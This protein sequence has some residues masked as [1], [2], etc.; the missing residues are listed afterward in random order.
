MMVHRGIITIL[1]AFLVLTVSA[2]AQDPDPGLPDTVRI[3]SVATVAGVD[4]G[5]PVTL[6]NDENLGGYTLPFIWDSADISIDSVSYIGTRIPPSAM[7]TLNLDNPN[8][9][10]LM[11]MVDF[12]GLNPLP[13]GDGLLFTI[14]FAVPS[15]TPD[16]FV[17]IDSSFYPPAGTFTLAPQ[18]G[19]SVTPQFIA[20]Q[21]K[22]GDPQPPPVIV[23]SN[24]S[25]VFNAEVGGG[26]PT[27][28]VQTITNGGGQTLN[29]QTA[30]SSAWLGVNPNQGTA[31]STVVITANI[32][33]L[34]AG[35]YY[36]TV[37]VTAAGATNS[38]Q[39]F[40]VTLNLTV[41]P[42]IIYLEP[43]S[44]YF[45]SLQDDV[46]PDSQQLLIDNIGQG[47]LNWTATEN[48]TWL[49]L[50]AY[51][52]VGT[53]VI[54]VMVDNAGLGPGVYTEQIVVSDPTATN[55]PQYAIV[56]FE[57]FSAYPVIWAEPESFYAVGSGT[58]D[59][60]DRTLLIH[61]N[62]G[63]IMDWT[64]SEPVDWM[65]VDIDTGSA[66]Q[67]DPGVV[68]VSFDGSQVYFGQHHSE[69]T[70]TSGN[71]ANS[72]VTIP[73][74][75]WKMEVPQ[76]LYVSTNNLYFTG[77]ECGLYG[78]ID[79]QYIMITAA[80]ATPPLN[81]TATYGA[82]WL[83]VAPLQG[84]NASTVTVE[85][86]PIGLAPGVYEDTIVIS[87]LTAINPSEKVAVTLTILPS[88]SNADLGMSVD[89]LVYVFCYTLVGSTDLTVTM[90]AVGGGCLDWQASAT[91]PWLTPLPDTGT[92]MGDLTIR[93]DAVGLSLGKYEGDLI[94]TSTTAPNTP[95]TLPV[96][97]WVYTMGDANGDALVNV[98]DIVYLLDYIFAGGPAPIP[99][100]FVGD[101]DCT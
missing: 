83:T 60:Y 53:A 59:P 33:G 43:D 88:P 52:G 87:S 8:R 99:L 6:W 69:I 28:Q 37:V 7:L 86:D 14:W 4:V 56:V 25:F 11:G 72:P 61:N 94:F 9:K 41:P 68:I 49:T 98:T 95:L 58:Q 46:N 1:L 63:G 70:I 91:V 15:G 50:S 36:D 2:V 12:S 16:Q 3:D 13:P 26:N 101:A 80:T 44:F 65:S 81:W 89:S 27:S 78:G 39:E 79:P 22:I 67:G 54:D 42:P 47:T 64:V 66:V 51:A 100:P 19:G 93:G 62:G 32:A 92:T 38:P 34:S 75:F 17:S 18:T 5:V 48:A 21:I 24:G 20:G 45:Q 35:T 29:W 30:W 77:V 40:T 76:R 55:D 85:V 10:V 96:D 57:I 73:V 23:L 31:P 90:F 74:T 82:S 84:Y 97:L 71:A